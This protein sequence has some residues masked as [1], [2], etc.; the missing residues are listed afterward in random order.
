MTGMAYQ[1]IFKNIPEIEQ[2]LRDAVK[3]YATA[4]RERSKR[5]FEIGR[6]VL[7]AWREEFEGEW[8]KET[9]YAVMSSK[10]NDWAGVHL[11]SA[12]GETLRK[13][14]DTTAA[15]ENMPDR[16]LF[17]AALTFE[18]FR[19]AKSLGKDGGMQPAELLAIA[20]NEGLTADELWDRY[21]PGT[22][23]ATEYE[24]VTGW[25]SSLRG[26]KFEWLPTGVR[27][28]ANTLLQRLEALLCG[29]NN[30]SEAE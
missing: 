27:K 10:V 7:L 22:E 17:E 23:G 26:A 4:D 19:T 12:S 1:N 18:H 20:Y 9:F 2:G 28:E 5:Q 8:L 30:V 13:W 29:G 24:R 16:A 15:F 25:I 14:C 21:G 11:V 6:L 3:G